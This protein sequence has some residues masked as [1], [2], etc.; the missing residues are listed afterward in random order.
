MTRFRQVCHDL[1]LCDILYAKTKAVETQLWTAHSRI[2]ALFRK[3][4]A[5]VRVFALAS[6]RDKSLTYLASQ[7][8]RRSRRATQIHQALPL[9]PQG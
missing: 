3:Q 5:V 8:S 1:V 4:L 9:L 6:A 2:N 7:G